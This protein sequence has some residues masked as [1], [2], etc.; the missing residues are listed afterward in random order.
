MRTELS[1][2]LLLFKNQCSHL[3]HIVA[4]MTGYCTVEEKWFA[5]SNTAGSNQGLKLG[6][7]GSCV[8]ASHW[9]VHSLARRVRWYPFG[10]QKGF[11]HREILWVQVTWLAFFFLIKPNLYVFKLEFVG[12]NKDVSKLIMFKSLLCG[13]CSK[14][15]KMFLQNGGSICF[16]HRGRFR[17]ISFIVTQKVWEVQNRKAGQSPWTDMKVDLGL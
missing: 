5:Q 12:P 14:E 15:A 6:S 11:S 13:P 8:Y 17:N 16:Q 1:L 9:D 2:C 10:D 7:L 4:I 3:R